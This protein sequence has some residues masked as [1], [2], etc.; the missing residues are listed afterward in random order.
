MLT[1]AALAFALFVLMGYRA[2][3]LRHQAQLTGI[4]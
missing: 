2:V 4:L 1:A 3:T